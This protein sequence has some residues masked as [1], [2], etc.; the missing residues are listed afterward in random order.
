MLRLDMKDIRDAILALDDE[1]LGADMWEILA[2]SIPSAK[3]V[4]ATIVSQ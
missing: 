1:K 4:S 3:E 2:Q